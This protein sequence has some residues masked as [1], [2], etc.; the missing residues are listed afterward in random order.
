MLWFKVS[1]ISSVAHSTWRW[2]LG[3]DLWTERPG[4]TG[5][6]KDRSFP[7]KVATS[8]LLGKLSL[9]WCCS[10]YDVLVEIFVCL[11]KP[12]F[13]VFINLFVI[14][15][16]L[17]FGFWTTRHLS[18]LTRD[19][20]QTP[21]TGRRLNYWTARETPMLF[22]KQN[23]RSSKA[24][25]LL[26][27]EAFNSQL[28]VPDAEKQR[29]KLLHNIFKVCV[30]SA[31]HSIFNAADCLSVTRL[32]DVIINGKYCMCLPTIEEAPRFAHTAPGRGRYP[33][34]AQRRKGAMWRFQAAVVTQVEAHA[35]MSPAWSL[36]PRTNPGEES[37]RA[38]TMQLTMTF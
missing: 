33:N 37:P 17:C 5:F 38:V 29:T 6:P 18:S 24:W 32:S 10:F 35:D 7:K 28:L 16:V 11:F 15:I 27:M 36:I 13:K 30:V 22:L 26:G 3:S 21:C 2:Y 31:E 34:Q 14:N 8:S 25:V 4:I 1:S 20:P 23:R 19:W 12:F 9:G